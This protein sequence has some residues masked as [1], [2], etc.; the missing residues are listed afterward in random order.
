MDKPLDQLY[1]PAERLADAVRA[2]AFE[3]GLANP[4][5]VPAGAVRLSGDARQCIERSA[6]QLGL[7]VQPVEASYADL[8]R[9][10]PLMGPA[11][12]EVSQGFLA[13]LR[14]RRHVVSV[15]RPDGKVD[16]VEAGSI[17]AAMCRDLETPLLLQVDQILGRAEVPKQ[18]RAKARE[19]IL[20]ERFGTMPIREIWL[21]R[22]PPG[23][24]FWKQLRRA[25]VP[26]RTAALVAFHGMQYLLWI[27][28]W[29]L[30]GAASLN[31]RF[32]QVWLSA[33]ML[34]LLTLVP[35]RVTITWLQGAAAISGAAILKQRLFY[36]AL[37][38]DPDS[39]RHQ[40]VGQ[41]L[42]RV[43]ESEALEAMALSGGFLGLVATVE[44][45][46]AAVVLSLGAGGALHVLA[47]LVWIVI[48]G[49]VAREYSRR[50]RAWTDAR[51]SMTHDLVENMAGHRTRLA[52]HPPENWHDEEDQA[53]DS[54]LTQSRGVDRYSALLG[55]VVP[56]GWLILS[57]VAMVPGFAS[58]ASA[59]RVA[60]AIGGIL[61]AWRAF[62]RL[63][64][65]LSQVLGAAVAWR[66]VAPLFHSAS[67]VG[68]EG[69]CTV[70]DERTEQVVEACD[71]TFRYRPDGEPVLRDCNLQ[72]ARNERVVLEGPS[73]GGKS[74]LVSLLTG[75]RRPESGVLKVGGLEA[76]NRGW[77]DWRRK[78]AA[79]PQFQENHVLAD[80]LAFNLLMA[81]DRMPTAEDL[82]EAEQVARELGLGELLSRMPS[83]ML[84]M[85][86]ET[87]W[88]L[89]H[90]ERS[91]VYIA[92]ALLQD[93]DLVVLDESF[94]AL[95]PEN[96]KLVMECVLKRAPALLLIAH[97]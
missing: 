35:L 9:Q 67:R 14:G 79:A 55:A 56:R 59:S 71:L 19:A 23:S 47:L 7:E 40:G 52:Q 30:I 38:M 61:L 2:L 17:R 5:G 1:W 57:L 45:V 48:A 95:D 94:A 24:S 70:N 22:L 88:Q 77:R 51:L 83:G 89:S 86:G 73:G 41:L 44:L 13:L 90:G 74:T 50:Y 92:R 39:M 53:L 72:I 34:L 63:V 37:H 4:S 75:M 11:L 49:A 65:G 85:V 69:V 58:G 21:L 84:Q 64:A 78:V 29:W 96:L 27:A 82:A 26:H 18:R 8:E 15:V 60:I 20:R 25:R 32:E 97:R 46:F 3:S 87:G 91:R 31:G 81:R 12:L 80:T 33:W 36:G 16:R 43:I 76:Q 66:R 28:A 62:K 42:G 6:Q 54:Y 10:L 68:D 93:S